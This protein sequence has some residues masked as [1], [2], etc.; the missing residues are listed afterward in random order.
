MA[1]PEWIDPKTGEE[2][3]NVFT[4]LCLTPDCLCEDDLLR[5][6]LLAEG[7]CITPKPEWFLDA[8]ES[9]M[10]GFKKPKLDSV[11]KPMLNA[12]SDP[13]DKS[14]FPNIFG[15]L[16]ETKYDDG[17][18]RMTGSFSV[19]TQLGVLKASISDK[20]NQ[21]VAYV[22]AL[23]LHELIETIERTICDDNTDWKGQ[24]PYNKPPY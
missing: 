24:K 14:D 4:H 19:W 10:A 21:R 11:L 20:D 9:I 3:G 1:Q 7:V 17:S 16:T 18:P 22:E 2:V 6:I 8:E 13:G 12:W 23:T 5:G 15:F